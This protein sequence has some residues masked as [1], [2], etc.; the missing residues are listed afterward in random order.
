MQHE[1]HVAQ[2]QGNGLYAPGCRA[3]LT[4]VTFEN[5]TDDRSMARSIVA[6]NSWRDG[7]GNLDQID[8]LRVPA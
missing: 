2:P 8:D 5:S 1:A 3:T 7:N 4:E 6:A